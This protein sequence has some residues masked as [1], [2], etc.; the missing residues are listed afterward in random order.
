[1]NYIK[2][3]SNSETFLHSWDVFALASDSVQMSVQGELEKK[4]NLEKILLPLLRKTHSSGHD[5]GHSLQLAYLSYSDSPSS[6]SSSNTEEHNSWASFT[7][8]VI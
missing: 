6:M 7:I 2:R 8:S 1:M 3:F 4:G 5:K